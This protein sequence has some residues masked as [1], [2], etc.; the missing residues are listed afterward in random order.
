MQ[1]VLTYLRSVA[2]KLGSTCKILGVRGREPRK[3]LKGR[4][5]EFIF[6]YS[7]KETQWWHCQRQE[8]GAPFLP[9][10]RE[11]AEPAV[12]FHLLL[13]GGRW[14]SGCSLL[15]EGSR[16]AKPWSSAS[17]WANNLLTCSIPVQYGLFQASLH[18][19]PTTNPWICTRSSLA[20]LPASPHLPHTSTP[21]HP[22]SGA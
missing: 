5:K 7:P 12:Q 19:F 18:T 9:W 20:Q 21:W 2:L 16:E 11:L 22:R 3:S 17:S 15:R 8:A 1:G 6:P 4:G 10:S 13:L 14:E